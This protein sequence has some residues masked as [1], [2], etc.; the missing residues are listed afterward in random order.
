VQ[1]NLRHPDV[2][3][4]ERWVVEMS[5][6]VLR[7]VTLADEGI[8]RAA[9]RT[10]AAEGFPFALA[11]TD[12]LSFSDYVAALARLQRGEP[13][14]GRFVASTFLLAEVDGELVGRTS[15]RHEL[16]DFL[17]H[18]GGHIGY[19]VLPAHRRRGYATEILRQSLEIAHGHGIDP[20][21]VTC[22]DGNVGSATVIERAGGVLE[23]TVVNEAGGLTRRYWI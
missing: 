8:V 11:L 22:D 21:L 18:E 12:D 4:H 3:L 20:V 19:C 17:R 2:S 15:I 1:E 6:V 7:T 23:D 16:N 13:P 14:L 5:T 9:H 10:M